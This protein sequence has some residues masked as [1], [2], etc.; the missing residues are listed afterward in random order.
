MRRFAALLLFVVALTLG[1]VGCGG[2]K[3][4]APSTPASITVTPSP[5][6]IAQGQV[7][8]LAPTVLDGSGVTLTGET[9]NY[10]SADPQNADVSN[11]TDT[12]FTPGLVCGGKWDSE[13]RPVVCTPSG[14]STTA[15]ITATVSGV[16]GVTATVTTY[17]HP[18]VDAVTVSPN[19]DVAGCVSQGSM[20]LLTAKAFN[21]GTDITNSV[22]P[23]TWTITPATFATADTSGNT[24]T[25]TAATGA[26]SATNPCNTCS[27]TAAQPGQSTVTAAV[28]N[29]VSTP[30]LFTTC[31][32]KTITATLADASTTASLDPGATA[33]LNIGIL[34]SK[35]IAL[36]TAPFTFSSSQPGSTTI[37]GTTFTA[38]AAG[39]SSIV[40]SCTP[41]SCNG[42]LYPVYSNKFITSVSGTSAT[43][44]YVA[45]TTGTSLVPIDTGTNTAGTAVTLTNTPNSMIIA[46]AGS[47]IVLGSDTGVMVYDITAGTVTNAGFNGKVLA[48]ASDGNNAVIADTAAN[49][50]RIASLTNKNV[51]ATFPVTGVSHAA[52]S[53]DNFRAYIVGAGGLWVWSP[54]VT[55]RQVASTAINDVDFVAQGSFAYLAGGAAGN[56]GVYASCNNRAVATSVTTPN[57][58]ALIRSLPNGSTAPDTMQMVAAESPRLDVITVTTNGSTNATTTGTC[59]PP[60]LTD[61]VA[62]FDFGVGAFTAKQLIATPDSSKVFVLAS[63]QPAILV[64]DA[65]TQATSKI[66][67][68]GVTGVFTGGVTLDSALLYVGATDNN[69]HRIDVKGSTEITPA[70]PVSFTPDLVAVRP[71]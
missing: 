39:T 53:A 54:G 61:S 30:V 15:T 68:S 36:A 62:S 49:V 63:D 16:T 13:K 34:D 12:G 29:A 18:K 33:T 17:V 55:P 8:Q 41:P 26:C 24:C 37:S 5:L 58:P 23:F 71:K 19:T 4:S 42:G 40:A 10:I 67:L 52:F 56:V 31:P 43:T 46:P 2:G 28:A 45:S 22:G 44:V 20:A 65:G 1:I 59:S 9:I 32:I 38:V 27:I 11:T 69:I 47:K 60:S 51:V 3:K 64:Y 7:V 70:I 48:I 50:V 6:S 21:R 25:F 14:T 57:M 66:P 35:D